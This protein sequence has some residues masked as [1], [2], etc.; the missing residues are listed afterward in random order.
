MKKEVLW[1]LRLGFSTKN[2]AEISSKGVGNF[3]STSYTYKNSSQEPSFLAGT[4]KTTKE[5]LAYRY[6]V[7][8]ASTESENMVKDIFKTGFELK[9]WWLERMYNSPYPLRE[10]MN[11]F[12]HNHF[13]STFQ[14]VKVPYWVYQHYKVIDN[15]TF[16]NFKTLTK[17]MMYSNAMLRYLD[18]SQNKKG[19][20]NENLAREL[21]EL[22]TLGEGNYSENDIRNTALALAGLTV[23][24][25]K[26][27]YRRRLMDTSTKTLFGKSGNFIIDD[28]IDIIFA[29]KNA[30]YF[31]TRKI[32]SW[33]IYDTPP[34]DLVT[35]YGDKL[36]QLDYEIA[37]FLTYVF[38]QEYD[39]NTMGSQIKN[40]IVFSLQVSE[41]LNIKPN[42]KFLTFFIKNQ[43]MD[44]Y[45]QP[46]VKGWQGGQSWLSSQVY[47][48]RAQFIDF[49]TRQNELYMR[50]I[51]KQ[52]ERFDTGTILLNP[53]IEMQEAWTP[54]D[55]TSFLA[56]QMLFSVDKEMSESM[57][58]IL[59]YDFNPKSENAQQNI[60]QLFNFLAKSPEFQVI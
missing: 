1:S 12:W 43:G 28:V 8:N 25:E 3:L 5:L 52:L 15:H 58:S 18:N 27:Q 13:V 23:G 30:P 29:Q 10:K 49:I 4:P 46:N 44:L 57:S 19:N 60:L 59:K 55:I 38:T 14:S 42:F 6:S 53:Y 9:A 50:K 37:P 35:L 33:F 7:K 36:K 32:L 39:K 22:F 16:G 56:S 20:I 47:I 21:L 2:R 48:Q 40:P 45:D 24:E 51:K 34:E 54:D 17:E 31:I 41:I 26:G 11:L